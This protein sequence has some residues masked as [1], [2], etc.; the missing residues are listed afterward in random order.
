M[1]IYSLPSSTS[2]SSRSS[3]STTASF[4]A[5]RRQPSPLLRLVHRFYAWLGGAVAHRART[6]ILVTTLLTL[7]GAAKTANTK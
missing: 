5:D 3:P 6:V 2:I 7:L 4:E 1:P